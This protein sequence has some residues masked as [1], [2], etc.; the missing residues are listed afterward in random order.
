MSEQPL[1]KH[2][3]SRLGNI[4]LGRYAEYFVK[5]EFAMH[6]FD[7]YMPE[8]DDKG[9]DFV[10][11][12]DENTYYDV[13]VKSTRLLKNYIFIT[14]DKFRLRPNLVAAIVL[15]SEGKPAESY[16]IPSLSWETPNGLLVSRDYKGGKSKPDYG[17]N[18][19]GKTSKLFEEYQFDKA[20][21]KL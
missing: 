16:L 21:Q 3:W 8:I 7:I 15:F 17:V 5:M 4:Q 9:I 1:G 10:V 19:S 6:G 13:Q 12:K 20:V 14:K 2:N 18:L 11:R